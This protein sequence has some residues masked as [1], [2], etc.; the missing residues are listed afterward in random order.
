[1]LEINNKCLEKYKPDE[2]VVEI[3]AKNFPYNPEMNYKEEKMS[4]HNPGCLPPNSLKLKIGCYLMLLRN[5]RVHEGLVNGTRLRL[6]EIGYKNRT[7]RCEILTGPRMKKPI[8][9]VF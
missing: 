5:W 6:L 3:I 4:S 2:T 1:M 9:K 7:M 8:V